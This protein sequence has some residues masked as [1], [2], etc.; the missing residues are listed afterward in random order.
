MCFNLKPLII[1]E[2]IKLSNLSHILTTMFCLY[3]SNKTL[4]QPVSPSHFP[5]SPTW[6]AKVKRV[7]TQLC[8]ALYNPMDCRLPGSSVHGILQTRILEWLAIAFS[9]GSSGPR[10]WTW[11]SCIA[12]RFFTIWTR[13]ANPFK[14][15]V[16]PFVPITFHP[17]IKVDHLLD[18]YIRCIYLPRTEISRTEFSTF[19]ALTASQSGFRSINLCPQEQ[20]RSTCLSTPS[21]ILMFFCLSF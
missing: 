17:N 6:T 18:V 9:R 12:G 15:S 13:T 4:P 3:V 21:P 5:I 8:P 20:C 1:G 19:L 14:K 7:V 16:F 2:L 11:V 10:D